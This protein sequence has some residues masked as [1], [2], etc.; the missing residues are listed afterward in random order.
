MLPRKRGRR[1]GRGLA[2]RLRRPHSSAVVGRMKGNEVEDKRLKCV[3]KAR[4]CS[5]AVHGASSMAVSAVGSE[6]RLSVVL[7]VR[8]INTTVDLRSASPPPHQIYNYCK[9]AQSVCLFSPGNGSQPSY[10]C[11][12]LSGNVCCTVALQD[13]ASQQTYLCSCIFCGCLKICVTLSLVRRDTLV[14]VYQQPYIGT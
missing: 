9:T 1:F 7:C 6:I 4:L 13:N 11:V 14:W 8:N 2:N 5:K 12:A 10:P 3:N